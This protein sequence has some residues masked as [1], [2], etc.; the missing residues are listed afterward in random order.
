MTT[1]IESKIG[2]RGTHAVGYFT[3]IVKPSQIEGGA[4]CKTDLDNT[5]LVEM[6]FETDDQ[7]VPYIKA[8]E[9]NA[10]KGLIVLSPEVLH[11]PEYETKADFYNGANT[12]ANV[13][14]QE[15]NK[16]FKTTAFKVVDA[17]KT[18]ADVKRG[19][20]SYYVPK[21]GEV[22]GYYAITATKP[23]DKGVN[24]YN[25][26]NVHTEDSYELLGL[27]YVELEII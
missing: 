17:S 24:L 14:V 16:T 15:S 8:L 18:I 20:Y 23:T 1:A 5:H 26:F 19:W 7:E 3:S 2:V 10:T 27:D 6:Y 25:V 13:Y 22:A 21:A 11:F 4:K 12:M 9:S